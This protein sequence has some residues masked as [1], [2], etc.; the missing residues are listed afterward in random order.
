MAWK[1]FNGNL[2]CP[3]FIRMVED[4][5]LW[6]F[7]LEDTKAF[8]NSLNSN[9]RKYDFSFWDM[10]FLDR[11]LQV[12]NYKFWEGYREYC[13][14]NPRTD[15]VQNMIVKGKEKIDEINGI[16]DRFITEKR[17]IVIQWEVM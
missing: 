7:E 15:L 5:D 3:D 6:K 9:P 14:N 4:R 11:E 2:R 12:D 17:Y 8:C 10:M 1:Y 16:L 13:Y